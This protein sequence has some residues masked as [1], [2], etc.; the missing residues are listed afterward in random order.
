MTGKNLDLFL[1]VSLLKFLCVVDI[2]S[3]IGSFGSRI[4]AFI[5]GSSLTPSWGDESRFLDSISDS[6]E[7]NTTILGIW[8]V[9]NDNQINPIYDAD[10]LTLSFCLII[11]DDNAILNEW[12]AYHYHTMNM[13]RLIV[14][15]DPTSQTSPADILK[16][17]KEH[18]E[19]DYTIWDDSDYMPDDFLSG[20][21]SRVPDTINK[22]SKE[23]LKNHNF[24]TKEKA[25][26][27]YTIINNHRFRQKMFISECYH[28]LKHE[29]R[30][31][32]AHIATDEYI[33]VN[34]FWWNETQRVN[35]FSDEV[36]APLMP[37]DG[38]LASFLQAMQKTQ[39]GGLDETPSCVM[40]PQIK[41]GSEEEGELE[42]SKY[43]GWDRTSFETLR[44]KVHEKP[45]NKK[46][47]FGK[48]IVNV[49]SLP[50]SH[51]IFTEHYVSSVHRPLD[52]KQGGKRYACPDRN[53]GFSP[54]KSRPLVIHHYLGSFERYT[55]RN[56]T[57]RNVKT[58]Q[59]TAAQSKFYNQEKEGKWWI[60]RW[61]ESFQETHGK[62]KASLVLG[63]Y[64]IS[65]LQ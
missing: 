57:R 39:M 6:P 40:M 63:D 33:A 23:T 56:D 16:P 37:S 62:E 5:S 34:P 15:V 49:F 28:Q 53:Q 44:W 50:E 27:D 17:W 43:N 3:P 41:F 19:L 31:W 60:G 10:R 45:R 21:Y 18:F 20:D 7:L 1:I 14:A 48:S 35:R 9:T 29:N 32:T 36:T 52:A 12:I 58:Y 64:R 25:M 38:S 24:F 46:N 61:L 8:G 13:R 59:M 30:T 65:S 55:A 4:L 42:D 22:P 26:K 54:T 11:K 51:P 47:R 2:Q